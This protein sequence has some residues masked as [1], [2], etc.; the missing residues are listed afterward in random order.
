[1]PPLIARPDD[2][3]IHKGE[4]CNAD[5]CSA[6]ET[7]GLAN[8]LHSLGIESVAVSGIA[9]EY[10]V[11]ATALD[12]AKERFEVALLTDLIRAV[13]SKA[14]AAV[15]KELTDAGIKLLNSQAWLS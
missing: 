7:T 1:M 4:A 12:A 2:L 15:L 14:T 8:K 6:F 9:T 3:I 5:G 11:R 10:C 13:D